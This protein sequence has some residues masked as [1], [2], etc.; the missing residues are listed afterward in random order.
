MIFIE[1]KMCARINIHYLKSSDLLIYWA[2]VGE[3]LQ[4]VN[5]ENND[6]AVHLFKCFRSL[7]Y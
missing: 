4:Q 5:M 6:S 3:L 1:A 2:Y 7:Q